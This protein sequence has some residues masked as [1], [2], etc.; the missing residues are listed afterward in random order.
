[1]RK[2]VGIVLAAGVALGACA[3]PQKIE[4][5]AADHE[6]KAQQLQAQGDWVG[7][8]KQRREAAQQRAKADYRA[9]QNVPSYLQLK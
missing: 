1:M 9:T 2:I 7:A 6:L 4:R 5:S 3:S 8:E